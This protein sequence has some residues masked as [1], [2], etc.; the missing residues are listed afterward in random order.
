MLQNQTTILTLDNSGNNGRFTLFH[1]HRQPQDWAFRP[2]DR[3]RFDDFIGD[4]RAALGKHDQEQRLL[5]IGQE[6]NAWFGD[7]LGDPPTSPWHFVIQTPQTQNLDDDQKAFLNVP[8]ELLADE[9]GH[10]AAQPHLRYNPYR[11]MGAAAP[12]LP[13]SDYRLSL[14]FM[15]AAPVGV[16]MLNFEEEENAILTAVGDTALDLEVEES[17]MLRQLAVRAARFSEIRQADGSSSLQAPDVIHLSC[18]G[19]FSPNDKR[20][21][22][23]LEDETGAP[24][25]ADAWDFRDEPNLTRGKLLFLS[26]CHTAAGRPKDDESEAPLPVDSLAQDLLQS[27]FPAVLGW[28]GSVRDDEASVFAADL[29]RHLAHNSSLV[30]AVGAARHGLFHRRN[31][32]G[33][34]VKSD[35]WHLARL[36]LAPAGGGP[37]TRGSRP[38]RYLDSQHGVKEFLDTGKQVPVATRAEF[39]GRRRPLQRILQAFRRH[40]HSGVLIHGMG[41]Q[42]KS[43]LASRV[44]SRLPELKP[45][46]VYGH[47]RGEDLLRAFAD[48][49][50]GKIVNQLVRDYDTSVRHDPTRMNDALPE[51]LRNPDILEHP[52]L[53]IIDDLEQVLTCSPEGLHRIGNLPEREALAASIRSFRNAPGASRLLITSRYRFTLPD[54]AGRDL[55]ER[56]LALPLPPMDE[57]EQKK[58][59]RKRRAL[60]A[61]TDNPDLPPEDLGRTGRCLAI[62][63]GNPGLQDILYR[64]SRSDPAVCDRTLDSL[65]DWLGGRALADTDD[66]KGEAVR[67]LLEGLALDKIYRE[68]LGEGERVLLRVSRLFHLPVP[69]AVMAKAAE[70]ADGFEPGAHRLVAL[71]LWDVWPDPV[72]PQARALALNPM[73]Q[74]LVPTPDEARLRQWAA[75]CIGVLADAWGVSS[76]QPS[77]SPQANLELTRLA[78]LAEHSPVI[79]ACADHAISW[80]YKNLRY[81]K[82]AAW[83][84]AAVEQ[85]QRDGWQPS[86]ALLRW[87]A[88]AFTII[89][90]TPAVRE[91]Y[92][93]ALDLYRDEENTFGYA[94]LLVSHARNLVNDGEPDKALE[95]F[96]KAQHVLTRREHPREYAITLGDIAGIKVYKGQIDGALALHRERLSVF[97]SL[98]DQRE[99]AVTLGDIAGIKVSKGQV[100]DGLALHQERLSVFESLGAQRERAVTLGD[101]AR[102]K[103]YKGQI[104]E[105]LA[106]HREELAVYESL[107]DRRSSAVT[108]C[109]IARIKVNKGQIDEA[110]ALH[111]EILSVFESLGDQRE[112][113][114]TLGDI[115]R[116]KVYKG[117]ID[118]ALALHQEELAVY[119]SLGEQRSRAVTLGDMGEIHLRRGEFDKA[120]ALYVEKRIIAEHL[121]DISAIAHA[122]W[123]LGRI[124][125]ERQDMEKTLEHLSAAYGMFMEIGRLE[126]IVFVG[127][128]LGGLIYGVGQAMDNQEFK[129]H[130]R[131]ILQRSRDGLRQLGRPEDAEQVDALL[132][133]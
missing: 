120:E 17:G 30:E 4:Y 19:G 81:R 88:D 91:Y 83:G 87:S 41:R 65:H 118:E 43:S 131:A 10:F 71:G 132:R 108:L 78:L 96:T 18:H 39:V 26:A 133:A 67:K 42:G 84:R 32:Q 113:A 121:G 119:E 6:L 22:L 104:D 24:A 56:L 77:H 29:Y 64:L 60:L 28:D 92:R 68:A 111:Q 25:L 54:D 69:E 14:L 82:A 99:R 40:D 127:L 117:Q 93:L 55:A 38:R 75:R 53:L 129:E 48:A 124:A 52:V 50:L 23:Y 70:L 59:L 63:Q 94:V 105:A 79:E 45:V 9:K 73:A 97:E 11:R 98:G 49:N 107:G 106:L 74:S 72:T 12:E 36:F 109:D 1:P 80:L 57:G 15:A 128:D 33:D 13:P 51:L 31:R 90:D 3:A 8:W 58:Q 125:R 2:Q 66:G 89:G 126:G 101:I 34:F 103:V 130:G 35:D 7:H 16:S 114:I 95:S 27:G 61:A 21:V 86:L 5:R 123:G 85:L 100:D 37:L 115:A 110:L 76:A 62:A 44:A 122:H 116:I 47:Y 112:R 46:V 102:I 20:P